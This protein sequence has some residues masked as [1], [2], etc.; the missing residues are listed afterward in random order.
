MNKE[1]IITLSLI[2]LAAACARLLPHPQN[3]TPIAAI[4]LF[5]GVHFEK[6][7]LAFA[8]PLAAM[9]ASD[10][11]L[12]LHDT[13]WAVYAGFA[14]TV[15]IGFAL[16]GYVKFLSVAV[17]AT[18]SSMLF[19]LISNIGVWIWGGIYPLTDQGLFAC[20]VAAIPFFVNSLLGD[21]F[22]AALLFGGFA[23]A[24]RRYQFLTVT[25]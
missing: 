13:L 6:K 1:R 3:V 23:M 18:L 4:A 24:G 15:C 10:L 22:Y 25:T 8:V 5:A 20:F 19:F 11:V 21:W 14:L 9:L 17:A 2:I 12:G 16:R 7:A